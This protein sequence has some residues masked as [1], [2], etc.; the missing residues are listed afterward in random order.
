M[1]SRGL[2][3]S[4]L[5]SL[6][7]SPLSSFSPEILY[8]SHCLLALAR[9]RLATTHSEQDAY[10]RIELE[11]GAPCTFLTVKHGYRFA[12]HFL[13]SILPLPFCLV[14]EWLGR[15]QQ[16]PTAVEFESL[17]LHFVVDLV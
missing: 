11:G 2:G 4:S 14:V 10:S 16:R 15:P 7:S 17:N 9:L 8:L 3:R 5:S 12:H 13:I 6:A 1:V